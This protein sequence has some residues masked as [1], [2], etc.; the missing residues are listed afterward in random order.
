[1]ADTSKQPDSGSFKDEDTDQQTKKNYFAQKC[2]HFSMKFAH[3]IDRIF[4]RLVFH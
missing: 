4:Y 3:T 2:N 1:M